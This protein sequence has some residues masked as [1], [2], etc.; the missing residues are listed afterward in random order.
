ML[1][2]EKLDLMDEKTG[3][4]N[5]FIKVS[6]NSGRKSTRCF[7]FAE[8]KRKEIFKGFPVISRL[9]LFQK[10]NINFLFYV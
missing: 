1:L 9:Y 3:Y 10:V 4:Q 6:Q 8:R 7:F 5:K 2:D